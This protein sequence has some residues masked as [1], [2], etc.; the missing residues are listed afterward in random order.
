VV[1]WG[2]RSEQLRVI[3]IEMVFKGECELGEEFKGL[4]GVVYIMNRI[5]PS[6]ELWGTPVFKSDGEDFTPLH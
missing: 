3:S 6:T 4:S 1:G 5:G 2:E